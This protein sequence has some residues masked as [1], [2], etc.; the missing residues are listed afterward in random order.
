MA[1]MKIEPQDR[2]K[3]K[4]ECLRLLVTLKLDPARMFL[5]SG[6]VDTYLRLNASEESAFRA[7]IAKIEVTQEQ[8]EVMQITTSWMEQ[9]IVLGREEGVALGRE[10]GVALGRRQA[11]EQLVLRTLAR[12]FNRSP[13]DWTD[14]LSALSIEQLEE[15]HDAVMDGRSLEELGDWLGS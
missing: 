4:V 8:E 2:P 3:V 13:E 1:K 15:L 11:T 12:K 14:R 7:E 10:E 9:G 6:F 5:I